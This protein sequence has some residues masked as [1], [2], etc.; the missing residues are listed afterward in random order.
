M[1]IQITNY[2][3]PIGLINIVSN[4]GLLMR[5]DINPKYEAEYTRA[6][7]NDSVIRQLENYFDGKLKVFSI[8]LN[9][10]S[11]SSFYISVWKALLDIPYGNTSSYKDIAANIGKNNAYRA[12]GTAIGKNPIPIIIPCH[13]VLKHNGGMGGFSAGIEVKKSL[14]KIEQMDGLK[15]NC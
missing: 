10:G 5:L 12:V 8:P 2:E 11:N 9:Y 7:F 1:D 15:K 3:A 6:R 13:R 4:D 14:L